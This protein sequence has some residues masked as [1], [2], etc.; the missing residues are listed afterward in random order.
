MR[1]S[2]EKKLAVLEQESAE[3]KQKLREQKYAVRY[4][5][6]RF[7]ERIKLERKIGKLQKTLKGLEH[8]DESKDATRRALAAAREDL[9]YV[10]H[11]PKGEKYVSLLKD[12]EDPEAQAHLERERERL[13][14]VVKRRMRDEAIVNELDEGEE[15]GGAG[16][17]RFAQEIREDDFF[18]NSDDDGNGD[19]DDDGDDDNDNGRDETGMV[20]DDTSDGDSDSDGDEDEDVGDGSGEKRS[21]SD[22]IATSSDRSSESDSDESESSDGR[23]GTTDDDGGVQQHRAAFQRR[24]QNAAQPREPRRSDSGSRPRARMESKRKPKIVSTNTKNA[25]RK[26]RANKANPAKGPKQPLRT[27]AEGGR[28]RRAK[29]K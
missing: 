18:A 15:D 8:D 20:G 26:P 16:E 17:G 6:V 27:R 28:K 10:L 11:F 9:E 5:K 22:L 13:R 1:S 21:F 23:V 29:K 12:A 2:L 25:D 4:H 14:A 3:N 7:F 19:D 24:H